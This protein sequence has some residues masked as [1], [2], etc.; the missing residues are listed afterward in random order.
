M[1]A[2]QVRLQRGPMGHPRSPVQ[3]VSAPHGQLPGTIE[4]GPIGKKAFLSLSQVWNFTP[5]N[6]SANPEIPARDNLSLASSSSSIWS[7]G[8]RPRCLRPFS[9]AWVMPVSVST[10]TAT[11]LQHK[12]LVGPLPS[13]THSIPQCQ[14]EKF[15]G[16]DFASAAQECKVSM[17]TARRLGFAELVVALQPSNLPLRQ[18]GLYAPGRGRVAHPSL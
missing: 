3:L 11:P 17:H 9:V 12:I 14:F 4:P 10:N 18:A 16:R 7:R 15:S 1:A 8:S 5:L 6:R 13:F 2:T